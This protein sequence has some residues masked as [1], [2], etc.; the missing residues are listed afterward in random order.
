MTEHG[1]QGVEVNPGGH[2]VDQLLFRLGLQSSFWRLEDERLR[3]GRRARVT[4]QLS[5]HQG[6]RHPPLRLPLAL[7]Q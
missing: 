6:R 2:G 3:Q 1:E 4:G 7:N 5:E